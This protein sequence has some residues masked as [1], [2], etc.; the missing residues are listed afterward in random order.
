MIYTVLFSVL[1]ILPRAWAPTSLQN[2]RVRPSHHGWELLG[3]Y[4]DLWDLWEWAQLRKTMGSILWRSQTMMQPSFLARVARP[5]CPVG[6]MAFYFWHLLTRQ[7]YRRNGAV[8]GHVSAEQRVLHVRYG[9]LVYSDSGFSF[10]ILANRQKIQ[11]LY[12]YLNIW[13]DFQTFVDLCQFTKDLWDIF[14]PQEKIAKV[15]E[16]IWWNTCY[17]PSICFPIHLLCILPCLLR[18]SSVLLIIYN[19]LHTILV[20]HRMGWVMVCHVEMSFV[21]CSIKTNTPL[22]APHIF[23]TGCCSVLSPLTVTG[24]WDWAFRAR[25]H[26]RD[27]RQQNPAPRLGVILWGEVEME[28]GSG[29]ADRT[30]HHEIYH[31]YLIGGN[32]GNCWFQTCVCF[33]NHGIKNMNAAWCVSAMPDPARSCS[34]ND[35]RVSSET[36][37]DAQGLISNIIQHQ[38]N[39][40][41]LVRIADLWIRRVWSGLLLNC[42]DFGDLNWQVARFP[43]SGWMGRVNRWT[44]E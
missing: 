36:L 2:P 32:C 27:S 15:A 22:L 10:W 8:L 11:Y 16:A 13:L 40:I 31:G 17:M 9:W 7:E 6:W 24:G 42:R 34:F 35:S 43:P 29:L 30:R 37:K 23:P 25:P 26:S 21:V 12:N 5:R 19:S 39:L 14:A 33:G 28:M 38:V 44:I 3:C 41:V 4:W 1:R 20:F 18:K